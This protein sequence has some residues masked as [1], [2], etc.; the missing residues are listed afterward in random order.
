L[1]RAAHARAGSATRSRAVVEADGLVAD[2][3][4]GPGELVGQ[5][6]LAVTA[7]THTHVLADERELDYARTV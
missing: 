6:D 4:D 5:R 2:P 1:V 7:N 3:N